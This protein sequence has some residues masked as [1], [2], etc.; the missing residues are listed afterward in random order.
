MVRGDWR[1]WCNA[2]ASFFCLLCAMFKMIAGKYVLAIACMVFMLATAYSRSTGEER[3]G[4]AL[5]QQVATGQHLLNSREIDSLNRL[6]LRYPNRK[7]PYITRAYYHWQSRN[8][9]DAFSDV[10]K[11]LSIDGNYGA[12]LH[13]MGYIHYNNGDLVK[14]KNYFEQAIKSEPGFAFAYQG[15]ALCVADSAAQRNA[16]EKAYYLENNDVLISSTYALVLSL[17]NEFIKADD[18]LKRVQYD[19]EFSAEHYQFWAL[20]NLEIGDTAGALAIIE[21]GIE[22]YGRHTSMLTALIQYYEQTQSFIKAHEIFAEYKSIMPSNCAVDYSIAELKLLEGDT[23]AAI[24]LLAGYGTT[25]STNMHYAEVA[26][27]LLDLEAYEETLNMIDKAVKNNEDSVLITAV[28]ALAMLRGEE[29]EVADSLYKILIAVQPDNYLL[30]CN[31]VDALMNMREFSEV[32]R[33]CDT[34]NMLAS[35]LQGLNWYYML[36]NMYLNNYE[37]A[38]K[39]AAKYIGDDTT[40]AAK[41]LQ[42]SRLHMNMHD[43]EGSHRYLEIAIAKGGFTEDVISLYMSWMSYFSDYTELANMERL[44]LSAKDI[45]HSTYFLLGRNLVLQKKFKD[46]IP[47]YSK[48]ITAKSDNGEYYYYR[49]AARIFSGDNAGGCSDLYKAVKYGYDDAKNSIKLNC[50]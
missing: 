34:I 9:S 39:Y 20:I 43:K 29:Y 47:Y 13:L 16:I 37:M 48:A 12:A 21:N 14:A 17:S 7:E 1:P 4:N 22:R 15:L 32:V 27:L 40:I 30:R 36:A 11:A 24:E 6:I 2:A 38:S 5:Q 3:K 45:D 18:V 35:D 25:C 23:I 31:R 19:E 33:Q 49:A 10:S 8:Q 50:K 42:V 44:L 46:A 26:A 41:Y 28:Y